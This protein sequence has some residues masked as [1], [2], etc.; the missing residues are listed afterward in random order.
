LR[1]A[2]Q[3]YISAVQDRNFLLDRLIQY[4]KPSAF[5]SGSEH[6]DESDEEKVKPDPVKRYATNFK[7]AL[8]G[9]VRISTVIFCNQQVM[10]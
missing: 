1:Q 6:S 8:V 9:I 4:E 7:N 3:K 5:S 2:Q 10:N